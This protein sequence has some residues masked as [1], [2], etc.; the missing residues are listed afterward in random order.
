[1]TDNELKQKLNELVEIAYNQNVNI[2]VIIGKAVSL[3]MKYQE[4]KIKEQIN[5]LF[6]NLNK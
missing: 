4:D 3:G 2:K 6:K 1:M 5:I